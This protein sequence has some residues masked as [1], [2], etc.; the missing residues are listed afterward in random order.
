MDD[1]ANTESFELAT[2]PAARS[3]RATRIA[4]EGAGDAGGAGSL[5]PRGLSAGNGHYNLSRRRQI[6]GRDVHIDELP[7]R[8]MTDEP[9]I[10]HNK[11]VAPSNPESDMADARDM[12]GAADRS[13]EG[14][15]SDP[16]ESWPVL[17]LRSHIDRQRERIHALDDNVPEKVSDRVDA[18]VE[19]ED[20][21]DSAE[22]AP[23]SSDVTKS[24]TSESSESSI[25]DARL[26][27]GANGDDSKWVSREESIAME[28]NSGSFVPNESARVGASLSINDSAFRDQV[29]QKPTTRDVERSNAKRRG[30][31]SGALLF[32]AV[33]LAVTSGVLGALL[34]GARADVDDLRAELATSEVTATQA[35]SELESRNELDDELRTLELENERL[36]QQI[37]DMSALVN[38][39]PAGRVSEIDVPFVP[40]FADE[41][42]NRLIAIDEAGSFVVWGEGANG[43]ITDV[44]AVEGSP[45]GL[46]ASRRKAWISTDLD[47]V[48]I[49]TLANEEGNPTVEYGPTRFLVAEELGYWTYNPE[50]REV[51]RLR[52][53]DG[54]VTETV[55]MPV[56]VVDMTIGAGSVWALGEDGRVYRINTADFTLQPIDAGESLIAI[57]AGPDALWTLSAADGALRRVDPVTGGVL[58]TV[59]VGRDPIDAV[60]AGNSVWVALRSGTSLIEVDTRTSAVVSRTTLPSVPV[61]LHRGDSGVFVAMNGD[62]PLV[63][64][65]SLVA[66]VDLEAG[67]PETIG[68]EVADSAD[69]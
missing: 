9:N 1:K 51:A 47:Q 67:E 49:V 37:V 23:D 69:G 6:V 65:S 36:E 53:S 11:D 61:A 17:D 39:L 19:A 31:F 66:P 25:G 10:A 45:T 26:N 18:E 2:D 62:V 22:E 60:F 8:H 42:N 48:E 30:L 57:S 33:V 20:Q 28:T 3:E 40:A 12:A 29:V 27:L 56:E 54:G 14:T 63:R 55:A 24:V 41:E 44:G 7:K 50:R 52:K 46:F 38:E 4:V 68:T 35:L 21:T 13:S 5:A 15:Q 58:V 32:A 16:D 34:L 59:P 64:V 43:P